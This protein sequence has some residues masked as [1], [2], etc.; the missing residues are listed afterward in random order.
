MESHLTLLQALALAAIQGVTEFLPISSSGHLVLARR[1]FGWSDA[2]GLVF[3]T[4]LH[5]GSLAAILIYFRSEWMA[6]IRG[7]GTPGDPD[8]AWHRRLPWLL[9]VA[10]L[11]LIL[12]GP[13]LQPY[14][15]SET[16]IRNT[17]AVGLSMLMT[18]AWFRLSDLRFAPAS[19]PIGFLNALL[20]GCAQIIALL[21]GASRSGWTAGAGMLCGQSRP[22]AVRF[23]FFMALPAI[24]GAIVFQAKDILSD[25]HTVFDPLQVGLGFMVSFIVSLCAIHFCLVFFRS[26]SLL[27]FSL[28]LA[29]MG[30]LA[31][32]V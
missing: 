23:S 8:Y 31:I 28:Y 21:P 11:P 25:A 30:L 10:T 32:L 14:L 18:A 17:A 24:A 16:A 12:A 19:R 7:Y 13:L 27:G 1:L 3:D 29:S 22:A 15:E 2:G 4:V 5:A 26:H 6:V 20:I 9:L